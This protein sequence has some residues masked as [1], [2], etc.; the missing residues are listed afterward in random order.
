MTLS[1]E[2]RLG[3]PGDLDRA[4]DSA[5]APPGRQKTDVELPILRA[6]RPVPDAR[7]RRRRRASRLRR[8][9]LTL[10]VLALVIPVAGLLY[11]ENSLASHAFTPDR[12]AVL[13]VLASQAAISLENTRLY[14]DLR[15]R[16]ARIRRLVDS[17]IIG[18]VI[19]AY[20]GFRHSMLRGKVET[21][22]EELG[23]A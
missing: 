18:I 13:K 10:N 4:S 15:E 5:A 7:L 23:E 6:Q 12:V 14:G 21:F 2:P 8:R 1:I 22:T 17:N 11:L 20:Y 16:E 19:Y 3:Q 9:I